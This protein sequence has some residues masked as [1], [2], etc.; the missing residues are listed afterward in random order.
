MG[1]SMFR[2]LASSTLPSSTLPSST[3]PSS[4]SPSST[5]LAQQFF[6]W[7]ESERGVL[8]CLALNC[9]RTACGAQ[10]VL[11]YSTSCYL[12]K[13]APLCLNLILCLIHNL[14]HKVHLRADRCLV[15]PHDISQPCGPTT[16]TPLQSWYSHGTCSSDNL[17]WLC[18]FVNDALLS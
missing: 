5:I 2:P 14:D 12:H 4:T 11:T 18:M 15:Q 16:A 7:L 1:R 17:L 10:V 9:C 6:C 3:L 8:I 13:T